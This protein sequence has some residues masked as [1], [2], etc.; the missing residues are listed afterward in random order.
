M[1]IVYKTDEDMRVVKAKL[2]SDIFL[3]C[4]IWFWR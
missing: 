4:Q 2:K 3:V 1:S